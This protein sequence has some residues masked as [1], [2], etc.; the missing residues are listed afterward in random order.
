MGRPDLRHTSARR[1]S[2]SA[3]TASR[4]PAGATT[5]RSTRPWRTTA[6]S[7]RA[8]TSSTSTACSALPSAPTWS[9]RRVRPHRRAPPA[10]CPAHLWGDGKEDGVRAAR[11][12]GDQEH[13]ARR[14]A[15]LGVKVVPGF[16]GSPI[17]HMVYSFPPNPAD[18]LEKGLKLFADMWSPILDVFQQEGVKFA[19]E[20]HPTEIAFDIAS[21]RTR[22]RR[23]GATRPSASTTTPATSA[24]R[25]WTTSASSASSPDR[26]FHVHMKDVYW[27]PMCPPRPA[28]SAATSTSATAALLGLPLAGP[29]PHRL[30]G[31]H[32]RAQRHRLPGPLSVEWEDGGMDREHGAAEACAFVK[33]LDFAPSAS[34]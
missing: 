2:P 5:S 17:W 32:P 4:S 31:D 27:S 10:S 28:S 25:A 18:F 34:L 26:I 7:S 1:P 3:T 13:R 9:A 8:G 22:S 21:A 14:E 29:R 20:V 33:R 15:K 16:T 23:S 30:R 6:T 24:T 11:G 19:L 12:R